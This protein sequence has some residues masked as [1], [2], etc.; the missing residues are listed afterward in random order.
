MCADSFQE[1]RSSKV[2]FTHNGM[3]TFLS[4][5]HILLASI[6]SAY[7]MVVY[8]LKKLFS[9]ILFYNHISMHCVKHEQ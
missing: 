9:L 8:I 3:K 7:N 2:Q 6:I 5:V 4:Y 1:H